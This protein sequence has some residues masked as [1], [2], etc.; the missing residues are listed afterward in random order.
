MNLDA[1]LTL[2]ACE[3]SAPL[4]LAELTLELARDEYPNLDVEAYLS[5]LDGL[6]HELQ[7]RLSG[8]LETQV[9]QLGRFLFHDLG[10]HGNEQDYYDPRNSYLNEVIDRRT[11]LPITLSVVTMAI[12]AR[13][14][15]EIAGVGLP[16]HFIVKAMCGPRAVLFDP[17]HEGRILSR[18]QADEIAS[19]AMG[20]PFESTDE[21]L[22]GV[23]LALIVTRI[24]MNLKGVY[25]RQSDFARGA[26]VIRR[27]RQL[28]PRD[29]QQW[30]DLG[31]T[32]YR[33]GQAG[34]AIDPLSA[35]LGITPTPGDAQEVSQW[36]N[37]A[38]G[39]V[40]RWN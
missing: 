12:G 21:L 22:R 40:A 35:Y 23:P 1:A 25:L 37:R 28:N 39:A 9:R 14:G 13:A 32:L 24:L 31:V 11:G 20:A 16:G 10:F 7:G 33:A 4:D 17:F 5:E 30:R 15:L 8:P 3:P 6:A 29:V 38:R 19:E 18:A 2:L 26:R 27:L 36:L 34:A